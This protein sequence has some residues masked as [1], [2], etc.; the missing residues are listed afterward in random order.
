MIKNYDD[1]TPVIFEIQENT[2]DEEIKVIKVFKDLNIYDCDEQII[3]YDY[4]K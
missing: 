1:D 4:I 3:I 2:D